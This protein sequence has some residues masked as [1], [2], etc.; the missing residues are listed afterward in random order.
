MTYSTILCRRRGYNVKKKSFEEREIIDIS[1]FT[2]PSPVVLISTISKDNIRNLAPVGCF[3]VCS[4]EPPMVLFAMHYGSDTVKN[5]QD[6]S[7]FV[8]GIPNAK[9][10]DNLYRCSK[11]LPAFEDEFVYANLSPI[12]SKYT[13]SSNINECSINLECK[14][15]WTKDSGDHMI[16]CGKVVFVIVE[17]EL[18]EYTNLNTL[19]SKLD[20]ICH[21]HRNEFAIGYEKIVL[22]HK[23]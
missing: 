22:A 21:I 10:L 19:R 7:D 18:A 9:I 17:G 5:I 4:Y 12:D 11:K 6:M 13:K 8:V 20:L 1:V 15:E 16:I 3:S 23:A 14:V 2:P